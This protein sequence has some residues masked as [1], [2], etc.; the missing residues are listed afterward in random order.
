M[1]A[2]SLLLKKT[3][4]KQG[5]RVKSGPFVVTIPANVTWV[6]LGGT[7]TVFK[8]HHAPPIAIGMETND[9]FQLNSKDINLSRALKHIF[10]NTPNDL[11]MSNRYNSELWNKLMLMKKGF[12]EKSGKA[13]FFETRSLS[14]YFIPAA[15]EPFNNIAWAVHNNNPDS[16]L[17]FESNMN[18]TKFE[19][20]LFSII[21]FGE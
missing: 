4:Q 1:V 6:G 19:E 15:D 5:L 9:T 3:L 14:V 8:Y 7:V 13:F 21:I 17:R 20:I 12:L 2:T 16:A 10:T 18:A 11:E